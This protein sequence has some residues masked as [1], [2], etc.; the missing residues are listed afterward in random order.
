MKIDS[1]TIGWAVVATGAGYLSARALDSASRHGW[2]S[3]TGTEPPAHPESPA[4]PWREALIWTVST[5][6]ALGLGRLL[7]QRL[8][9]AGW[10]R[11]VGEPPPV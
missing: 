10:E 9:A 4:T 6:L 2:K 8:A 7:T 11:L 3:L 5:S 1:K